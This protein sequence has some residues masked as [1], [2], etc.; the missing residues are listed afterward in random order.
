MTLFSHI[1][2]LL[3]PRADVG[4]FR[5]ISESK[6]IPG[7]RIARQNSERSFVELSCFGEAAHS[8]KRRAC[9]HQDNKIARVEFDTSFEV[10]F[11]LRPTRGATINCSQSNV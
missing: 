8:S 6:K 3:S 9:F 11:G 1:I 4:R 2:Q 5:K 10:C 7:E